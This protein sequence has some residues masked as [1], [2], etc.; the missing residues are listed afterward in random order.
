V[1]S[2]YVGDLHFGNIY[3]SLIDFLELL[4]RALTD[5]RDS[6]IEII[7]TGDMLDGLNKYN[8][9]AYKQG[10]ETLDVQK[11]FVKWIIE[12]IQE[13]YK[14]VK[15]IVFVLGNHEKDFRGTILDGELIEK[16]YKNVVVT[17]RYI[18]SNNMLV[19]HMLARRSLIGSTSGFTP[20]T[21]DKAKSII[22]HYSN[23]GKPIKG[24]VTAH[25]HKILDILYQ[26][27]ITLILLPSFLKTGYD[28]GEDYLY[29]PCLVLLDNDS[30][31]VYRKEFY[32]IDIIKNFN[33]WFMS[34]LRLDRGI[35]TIDTVFD[36][37]SKLTGKA[38]IEK[39]LIANKDKEI[40]VN[41]MYS[42]QIEE[43]KVVVKHRGRRERVLPIDKAV[44]I[45]DLYSKGLSIGKISKRLLGRREPRI[46]YI[47]KAIDKLLKGGTLGSGGRH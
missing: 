36:A 41:S 2:L 8:T 47:I 39:L 34:N 17:D 29:N 30:I 4:D 25:V 38:R 19:L 9:Q 11:E 13:N 44:M 32:S 46:G 28:V 31:K 35:L 26:S 5:N 20:S 37:I 45:Y 33:E 24:L 40:R 10:A 3:A 42:V 6:W 18:D 12:H 27:G 1:K 43:N 15:R 21:V 23:N 16:V 22:I 7:F 14:N